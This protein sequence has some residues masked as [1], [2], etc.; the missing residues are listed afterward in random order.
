[1]E[2]E[3]KC[4]KFEKEIEKNDEIENKSVSTKF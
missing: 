3:S 1:M 2:I 4:T